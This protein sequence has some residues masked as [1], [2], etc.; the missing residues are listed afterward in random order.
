MLVVVIGFV[1]AVLRYAGRFAGRQLTSNRWFEVQWYLF[2]AIFLL[3]FAYA[4]KNSINVRVDVWSV[5]R[6]PKVR[7]WVDL[8]G[9]L[10]ALVPFAVL[11]TLVLWRPILTSWGAR[12]D[13]SFSTWQVWRVWERS[14]DPQGLPRA[15][16]KS[17]LL[18][19]FVLLL[20]QALAELVKLVAQLTGHGR[21]VGVDEEAPVRVE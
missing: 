19:G 21:A 14:P 12:P 3:A 20:T 9:H 17:L 15:P 16:V 13:G 6:S 10:V 7:A 2:A 1:N 4:L 18:V 8:V 5:H 11:A